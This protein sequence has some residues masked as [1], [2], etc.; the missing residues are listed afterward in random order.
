MALLEI[1]KLGKNFGGLAA[2][3][4]IDMVVEKGEIHGLI[5]PNGAGK[6][7][8]FNVITGIHKQAS[9]KVIFAGEDITGLPPHIV[10]KKGIA[11]TFQLT[12]LFG[13]MTVMGNV[14]AAFYI[15]S[16]AGFFR[17]ILFTQYSRTEENHFRQ[18]ATEILSFLEINQLRDKRVTELPYGQKRSVSLAVA[19]AL[20]PKLLLLDEPVTGMN[21]HEVSEMVT[22]IKRIRDERE[23][24]V[25]I[26]EHN[27][28][29]IM[30]IC[31]CISVLNFG[32]KIAEGLPEE[33]KSNKAVIEA[34]L[35][36]EA[37]VT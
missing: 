4:N 5:G 31:D 33:I 17:D 13:N 37:Y 2:L 23:V 11:R 32:E 36:A 25:L 15:Q 21:P 1:D 3:A 24:T 7:T 14:Q 8:L 30:T 27:M 19:L 9:G 35:G 29:T 6:S 16:K 12:S 26:I 28:Q 20:D 34:Y 22:L 10:S 18:R